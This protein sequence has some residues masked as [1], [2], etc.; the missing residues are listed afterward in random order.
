MQK[1]NICTKIKGKKLTLMRGTYKG[2]G[3]GCYTCESRSGSDRRCEDGS[4]TAPYQEQC[5]PREGGQAF[6][7]FPHYCVKVVGLDL[8]TNSYVTIRSCSNRFRNECKTPIMVNGRAIDGCIYSCA[9]KYC[10]HGT[11]LKIPKWYFIYFIAILLI[12]QGISQFNIN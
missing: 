2:E 5:V 10:N 11:N 12:F 3:L 8:T 1:Q 4:Y 6:G 9:G 7:I